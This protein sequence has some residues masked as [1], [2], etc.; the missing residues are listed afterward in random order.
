MINDSFRI[1]STISSI[2][3]FYEFECIYNLIYEIDNSSFPGRIVKLKKQN[4]E[5]V[6]NYILWSVIELNC[7]S[8]KI[9]INMKNKKES[10]CWLKSSL[11]DLNNLN[12]ANLKRSVKRKTKCNNS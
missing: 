9:S 12:E 11:V 10:K 7:M 5:M 8:Q 3:K 1:Y 4:F 6:R 2:F